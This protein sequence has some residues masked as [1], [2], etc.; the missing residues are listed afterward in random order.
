[1][2]YVFNAQQ[3]MVSMEYGRWILSSYDFLLE[4]VFRESC[5][6]LV[7]ISNPDILDLPIHIDLGLSRPNVFLE[8]LHLFC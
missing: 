3:L 4:G 8:P 5:F 2:I 6:S 1:M 7:V